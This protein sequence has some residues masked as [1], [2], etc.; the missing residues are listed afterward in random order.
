MNSTK[1]VFG[2]HGIWVPL[3]VMLIALG[4]SFTDWVPFGDER[5]EKKERIDN[6]EETKNRLPAMASSMKKSEMEEASQRKN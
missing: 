3:T 4:L 5:A 6:L 2:V 1:K